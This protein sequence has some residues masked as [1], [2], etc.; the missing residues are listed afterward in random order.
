MIYIL[1]K[2]IFF[3]RFVIPYLP[4]LTYSGTNLKYSEESIKNM[5]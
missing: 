4:Q 5:I 2:Y 3:K 1:I